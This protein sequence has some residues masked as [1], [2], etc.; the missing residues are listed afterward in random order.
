MP[1]DLGVLRR[2][3]VPALVTWMGKEIHIRYLPTNHT[4]DLQQRLQAAEGDETADLILRELLAEWDITD[5][6]RA[7]PIDDESFA[8]LPV[9][10]K[11]AIVKGIADDLLNP[12]TTP[13]RRTS[14]AATATSSSGTRRAAASGATNGRSASPSG[15][16]HAT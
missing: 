16:G 14:S 2:D 10:L 4:S 11:L 15:S 9:G 8:L 13:T 6:D 7:L 3:G 12:T 1:F 5:G